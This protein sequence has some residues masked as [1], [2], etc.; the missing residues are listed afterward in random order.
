MIYLYREVLRIVSEY[1]GKVKS[2]RAWTSH[3]SNSTGKSLSEALILAATNPQYVKRL[4]M[5]LRVQYMKTT[6]SEQVVYITCSE[7]VVFMYW[8][9]NSM[10]NLLTYCGLVAA[11]IS[12]SEKDLPVCKST[13]P[14]NKGI[15]KGISRQQSSEWELYRVSSARI[16]YEFCW[17]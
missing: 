4:F 11:R 2:I 10:N 9:C 7:F 8:T 13:Q 14:S 6:S 3:F 15:Y 5:E 1:K 16:S 12:A 17:I